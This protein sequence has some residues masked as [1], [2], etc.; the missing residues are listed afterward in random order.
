MKVVA[1]LLALLLSTRAFAGHHEE[2]GSNAA[3]AE[4]FFTA[5]LAGDVVTARNLAHSDIKFVFKGRTHISNLVQD[6]EG[7]FG[8]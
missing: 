2:S 5:F 8:N 6:K 1:T 4:R 7:F 3:N